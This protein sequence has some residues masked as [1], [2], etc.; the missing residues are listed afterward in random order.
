MFRNLSIERVGNWRIRIT[1]LRMNEDRNAAGSL[2]E[3]GIGRAEAAA[4]GAVVGVE[5]VSAIVR[6][7]EGAERNEELCE[8]FLILLKCCFCLRLRSFMVAQKELELRSHSFPD[9]MD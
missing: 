8:S 4:E 9:A 3:N 1:V 6:V 2:L 7:E 5:V